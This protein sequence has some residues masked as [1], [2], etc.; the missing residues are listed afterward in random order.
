MGI[1]LFFLSLGRV[2]G[3]F[4]DTQVTNSGLKFSTFRQQ[5]QPAY[6]VFLKST[7]CKL[8]KKKAKLGIA[9]QCLS[10]SPRGEFLQTT[11]ARKFCMQ[12]FS[13]HYVHIYC[14]GISS[15]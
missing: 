12:Y 5:V 13:L 14:K 9:Q 11:L 1:D 10:H 3:L 7:F 15:S 6:L 2:W 8:S 4:V